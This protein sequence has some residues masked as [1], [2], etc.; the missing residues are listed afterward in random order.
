MYV[1]YQVGWQGA[2]HIELVEI[3]EA[4]KA[5]ENAVKRQSGADKSIK[6]KIIVFSHI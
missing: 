1:T 4:K 5:N 6:R 3:N 2:V